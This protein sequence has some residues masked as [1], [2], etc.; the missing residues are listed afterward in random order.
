MKSLDLEEIYD[1]RR[2]TTYKER[3]E[4]DGKKFK[5]ADENSDGRLDKEEFANFLHPG[6]WCMY[7]V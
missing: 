4:R 1:D 5:V 2:N 3:F 6:V 7:V